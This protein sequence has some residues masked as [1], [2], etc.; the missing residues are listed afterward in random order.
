[1]ETEEGECMG[2]TH[3]VRLSKEAYDQLQTL[4]ETLGF[5]PDRAL[6]YA[7]RLVNACI[8][9]GF[10]TDVP[11][12]AQPKDTRVDARRAERSPQFSPHPSHGG[13]VLLSREGEQEE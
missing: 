9:E 1:M 13:L 10:L 2:T 5:P 3:L 12:R 11:P 4:A 7:I 8:Q 6:E